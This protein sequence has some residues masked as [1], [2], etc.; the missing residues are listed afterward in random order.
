MLPQHCQRTCLEK[1]SNFTGGTTCFVLRLV[2]VRHVRINFIRYRTVSFFKV[3]SWRRVCVKPENRTHTSVYYHSKSRVLID[4]ITRTKYIDSILQLISL[5]GYSI[6]SLIDG[7]LARREWEDEGI[8]LLQEGIM[9]DAVDICTRLLGHKPTSAS[10]STW[11][12]AVV[13]SEVE[14]V[15]TKGHDTQYNNAWA[16]IGGPESVLGRVQCTCSSSSARSA[17]SIDC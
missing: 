17:T 6:F 4:L 12:V 5:N 10:I 14:E 9:R 3:D 16:S 1:N 13:R 2:C 7:I 8:K 15:T 11:A